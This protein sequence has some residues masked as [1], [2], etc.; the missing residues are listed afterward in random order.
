M[1]DPAE[2]Q[3]KLERL[4]DAYAAQL[5]EKFKHIEQVW[6]QLPL[7]SWDEEGFQT[8][9][10]LVHSLTGSGKTF[11]FALLSDVAR[12]LEEHLNQIA[13]AKTALSEDQ[14]QHIQKL[15][16]ELRQVA[17]YRETLFNDH[18]GLIAVAPPN[19]DALS[20][21]RIFVL[22]DDSE[23]AEEL[24]VQLGYF[25]YEVTVFNTLADFRFVMQ[26]TSDVVILTD[27]AFPDNSLGGI[28]VIKEIQQGREIPFPVIFISAYDEFLIRLEAARAGG[29]AYLSKPV[30]IGKLIDK[31]DA[32]AS[33]L[34]TLPYRVMIIDDS[35]DITTYYSEVLEQAGMATKVVHNPLNVIKTL[36]EFAPDLIL[37]D[38]YMPKCNGMDLAKVIRQL[39]AFV[40]IPIVF[41]SAEIDLDKQLVAMSLG[42]DD[43]LAKPILP[44]HLISSV[45]SRIRRS[46]ILRSLVLRDSL[47]GLF[48]HTAIKDEL[49][50]EVVRS[51]RHGTS[52][53]FA[54][55]DIDHFKQINDTYGHPI[56]D[57]V[58]KSLAR[59][60]KQRLRASDLVGRYGGEEFAV[61]LVNAD[62]AA[63]LQVLD[64]IRQD[65]SQLRHLSDGKE[66]TV[67]FSCGI[68][69]V[70]QFR[71]ATKLIE[72][73]DKAL[74]NAKHAGRNQVV[75]SDAPVAEV[76]GFI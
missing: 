23:Q 67:T 3:T 28:E 40:S 19:H 70:S 69:D 24:K 2:L 13:Q 57:R 54:M 41:L 14:R 61:I 33:T 39:D 50:R 74:Y 32:L 75:L 27:I 30:N 34:T 73:S 59:L 60:L 31:L 22:E 48:N 42:G 72:A 1:A 25:G 44:Q 68:A 52:L 38:L 20:P 37:I 45:N 49:D 7:D 55:I 5:P 51:K 21:R 66:F 43:F 15:M 9:H 11:G 64:T 16:S 46:L 35:I 58:I 29:I 36:L 8:L 53:A 17:I 4:C 56:G 76:A 26:R 18:A 10:R 63:A 47:T 62:R 6:E 65:F 71:E 12:D